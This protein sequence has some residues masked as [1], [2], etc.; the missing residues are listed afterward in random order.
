MKQAMAARPSPSIE[1]PLMD[2]DKKRCS[3]LDR[4]LWLTQLVASEK[5]EPKSAALTQRRLRR[6]FKFCHCEKRRRAATKQS[7][8]IATAR[9]AHFAM[10]WV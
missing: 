9:F 7:S 5:R 2:A 3:N 8:W 1:A 10:T 6:V 4:Y